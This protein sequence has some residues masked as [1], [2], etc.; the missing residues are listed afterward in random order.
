MPEQEVQS[1]EKES[2]ELR[3]WAFKLGGR[4]NGICTTLSVIIDNLPESSRK[5]VVKEL[6]L[7]SA[8]E[9][10][11]ALPGSKGFVEMIEKILR[12]LSPNDS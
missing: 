11:E 1:I 3:D 2:N 8:K 6:G 5:E 4:F 12:E 10:E 7:L 9:S